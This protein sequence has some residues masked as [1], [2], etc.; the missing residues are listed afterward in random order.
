MREIIIDFDRRHR[1]LVILIRT[2]C[3]TVSSSLSSFI[4]HCRA[5][6]AE[7]ISIYHIVIFFVFTP[8]PRDHVFVFEMYLLFI[9][10][11]VI[12]IRRTVQ[13]IIIDGV[14]FY[15]RER[16]P[17]QLADPGFC[18]GPLKNEPRDLHDNDDADDDG[19][20]DDDDDVRDSACI[21][22]LTKRRTT[23]TR[24]N[25]DGVRARSFV[26]VLA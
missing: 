24:G 11:A 16:D 9:I 26:A 25:D 13:F 18:H 22:R 5:S 19:D 14:L 17:W 15:M 8:P 2:R 1:F 20:D 7:W 10:I 6:L 12:A 3:G 21:S 23:R 4:I